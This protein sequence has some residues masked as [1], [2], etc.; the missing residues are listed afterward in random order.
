MAYRYITND[1]Q[2]YDLKKRQP[3][4]PWDR[5]AFLIFFHARGLW[6]E[7]SAGRVFNGGYPEIM[8][9]CPIRAGT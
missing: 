6:S 8:N 1:L 5:N 3:E 9:P 7:L 4:S 2:P